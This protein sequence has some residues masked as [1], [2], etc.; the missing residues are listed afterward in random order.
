LLLLLLLPLSL[1]KAAA[2]KAVRVQNGKIAFSSARAQD[3]AAF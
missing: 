3:A 1:K 2:K